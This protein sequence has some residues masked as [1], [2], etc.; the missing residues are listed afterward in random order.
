M[1]QPSDTDKVS[2]AQIKAEKKF[3]LREDQ[4]ILCKNCGHIITSPSHVITVNEH[5]WHT[6]VN[7]A[8][9]TYRIGCFSAADG[10]LV[11]GEPTVDHTWFAGFGWNYALCS[12][13]LTHLGWYYQHDGEN[14]F[15]LI[16][17]LLETSTTH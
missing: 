5:H 17:D 16:L 2:H 1:L 14:F 10:C 7:P 15:G 8:R 3:G 9:V 12:G 13:C 4:Y 6:F 11:R